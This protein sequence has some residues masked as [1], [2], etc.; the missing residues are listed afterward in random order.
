MGKERRTAS[1]EGG[2]GKR[3]SGRDDDDELSETHGGAAEL[4]VGGEVAGCP[5]ETGGEEEDGSEDTGTV[6]ATELATGADVGRN[7]GEEE[8]GT[9]DDGTPEESGSGRTTG[10]EFT[11]G[12]VDGTGGEHGRLAEVG[13]EE[14]TTELEEVGG[15]PSEEGGGAGEEEE[16]GSAGL[17]GDFG[18]GGALGGEE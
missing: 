17:H 8:T 18:S 5:G 15:A 14:V 10:A 16:A 6:S 13:E 3:E 7:A 2:A 9:V 12:E 4:D 11:G 1:R